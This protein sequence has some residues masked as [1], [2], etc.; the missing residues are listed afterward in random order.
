MLSALV[1]HQDGDRMPGEGFFELAA[2]LGRSV[3]DKVV[4]W[5]VEVRR[6][7]AANK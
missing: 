6:V 4:L 1:V 5:T 3:G 7:F 2:Y